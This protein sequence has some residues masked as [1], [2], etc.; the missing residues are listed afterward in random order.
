MVGGLCRSLEKKKVGVEYT[1]IRVLILYRGAHIF[2]VVNGYPLY[3]I[4]LAPQRV[5]IDESYMKFKKY[6]H[7]L[8]NR[9]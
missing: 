3:V 4:T 7:K 9:G 8:E 5:D 2:F 6:V 1:S